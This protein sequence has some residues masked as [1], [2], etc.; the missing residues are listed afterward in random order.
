MSLP[1]DPSSVALVAVAWAFTYAVHSTILLCGAWLLERRYAD[2]P[3]LM[4]PIWK[5]AVL[6]GA[7]SATLQ[8]AFAVDPALGRLSVDAQARSAATPQR[9]ADAA[10]LAVAELAVAPVIA[11]VPM[12]PQVALAYEP[13]S[14]PD[15][16]QPAL[17]TAQVADAAIVERPAIATES[18]NAAR[19]ALG[20]FALWIIG[21]LAAV[22]GLVRSWLALRRLLRTRVALHGGALADAFGR[23]HARAGGPRSV[24]L[25]MSAAIRVPLATG[26][27]RPE[28]VVPRRAVA[29]LAPA[30]QESMLAHELGHVVRRDPAWRL[31]LAFVQR[32]LFF[33]PLIGVAMRRITQHAEYLADAWAARHTAEPLALARCLTEIAAWMRSGPPTPEPLALASGMAEPASILGR[34]VLRL[35][36]PPPAPP[37]RPGLALALACIAVPV[38]AW[39]APGASWAHDVPVVIANGEVLD[40]DDFAALAEI[41][42][43]DFR[44]VVIEGGR[45]QGEMDALQHREPSRAA[46]ARSDDGT[47]KGRRSA[48][49]ADRTESKQR[50]AARRDAEREIKQAFRNA[51]KRDELPDPARIAEIVARA[52]ADAHEDDGV[53]RFVVRGDADGHKIIVEG[54]EHGIVVRKDGKVVVKGGH[55]H[56]HGHGHGKAKGH[57]KGR[58]HGHRSGTGFEFKVLD[59]NGN[60]IEIRIPQE[61]IEKIQRDVHRDVE[62]AMREMHGAREQIERERARLLSERDRIRE[63]MRQRELRGRGSRPP[64][65]PQPPPPPP[66]GDIVPISPMPAPAPMPPTPP[67]AFFVPAPAPPAMP[68]MPVPGLVPLAPAPPA[69]AAPPSS[70]RRAPR[71]APKARPQPDITTVALPPSA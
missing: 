69:P 58:A 35:V 28:I 45:A 70:R 3:E 37:R 50:A 60:V 21:G 41:G 6:G 19:V 11:D 66:R 64:R 15:L 5:A 22:I 9:F 30:A 24:A 18:T 40:E 47:R 10:S 23:L 57:A 39:V 55:A 33:Q 44:M 71:P 1:F 27:V 31:G 48:R 43:D 62:R 12:D 52:R 14:P 68:A 34:R 46:A 54:D 61:D 2:K 4:S 8:M 32:V 63:I 53:R 26:V 36:E 13:V 29:E 42:D 20:L 49:K 59:E 7:L 65:A 25:S 51:K 16:S 56:G 38:L 17:A 67:E